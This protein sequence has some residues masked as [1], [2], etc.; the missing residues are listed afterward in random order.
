MESREDAYLLDPQL[1]GLSVKLR[2]GRALEVEVY[3]GSP[4][5]LKVAGHDRGPMESWQKWSFPVSLP[6][7]GSDS[8]AGWRPVLKGR[9]IS[10]SSLVS[11]QIVARAPGLRQEPAVRW[12]SL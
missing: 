4:G 7:P 8:P 11:G 3:C 9:C 2:G 6:S 5:I 10:R 12:N 1:P